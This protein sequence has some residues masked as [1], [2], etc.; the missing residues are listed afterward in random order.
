[1]WRYWLA[2]LSRYRVTVTQNIGSRHDGVSSSYF[3]YTPRTQT[4]DELNTRVFKESLLDCFADDWNEWVSERTNDWIDE[5][6]NEWVNEWTSERVNEWVNEWTGNKGR[7][8]RSCLYKSSG[9]SPTLEWILQL[10]FHPV[11]VV[12]VVVR[13]VNITIINIIIII[14]I[15][16]VVVIITIT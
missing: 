10:H 4:D 9:N 16:D 13:I 12:V 7:G 15:I 1:M 2:G 8:K 6:V 5:R 3:F 11:I 14:I